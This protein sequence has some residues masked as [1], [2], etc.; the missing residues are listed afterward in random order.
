MNTCN[1]CKY[2]G[3]GD[4]EDNKLKDRLKPCTKMR[5]FYDSTEWP[6]DDE[7]REEYLDTRV[8]KEEFKDNK[9]FVQ[10]GSDYHAELLVMGDFG[11][12]H[13]EPSTMKIVLT[14]D[15]G[16]DDPISIAFK[17]VFKDKQ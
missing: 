3:T 12:V 8:I 15:G 10:D 2:W 1:S 16:D 14:C 7:D 9:A 13:H 6:A 5:M 11:C 17:N 4:D